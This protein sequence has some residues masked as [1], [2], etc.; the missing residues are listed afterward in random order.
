MYTNLSLGN[1]SFKKKNLAELVVFRLCVRKTCIWS[2][3]T[4]EHFLSMY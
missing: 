4:S 2:L 1:F 3:M